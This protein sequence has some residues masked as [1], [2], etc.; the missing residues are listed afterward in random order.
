MSS[1]CFDVRVKSVRG[2][3]VI[4]DVLTGTAGGYN[5][6]CTSR[7]FALVVLHHALRRAVD[8]VRGAWDDPARDKEVQR[9]YKKHDASALTLALADEGDWYVSEAWMRENVGRFVKECSLVERRNDLDDEELSR[10]AVEIEREF[11]GALYTNQAHLWQPRRW[12][13]CHNFTLRVVLADPKWGEH[14]EEGLTFGT[15][16]YDVW[17]DR[18]P[19]RVVEPPATRKPAKKAAKKKAVVKKAAKKAAVKKA[20]AKKTAKK[21]VAKKAVAKKPVAKKAPK[22]AR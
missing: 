9:L 11:G 19:A 20:A 5:D 6:L 13:R 1:D 14:L 12:E 22:R 17:D 3:E 15:T 8:D 10:R 7:S 16:A 4:L 18:R 21:A 2:D